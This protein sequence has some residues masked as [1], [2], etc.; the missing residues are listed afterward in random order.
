MFPPPCL[1]DA[2]WPPLK[3][4]IVGAG[5]AGALA[6]LV[7]ARQGFEVEVFERQNWEGNSWTQKHVGWNV[8]VTGR[9]WRALE[10]VGLV[11]E[12]E[13]RGMRITY[14]TGVTGEYLGKL[15]RHESLKEQTELEERIVYGAAREKSSG[16]QETSNKE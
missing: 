7:L 1:S 16:R 2:D 8:A 4:V 10:N 9:A 11:K 14:V 13:A 15:G 6:A 12:V 3:A 5:P